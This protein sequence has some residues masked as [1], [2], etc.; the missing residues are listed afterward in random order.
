MLDR[1]EIVNFRCLRSV[2]VPLRPLTI[3]VGPNDSGKSALLTAIA[4]AAGRYT[5]QLPDDRWR[6]DPPN[7]IRVSASSRTGAVTFTAG[8]DGGYGRNVMGNNPCARTVVFRLPSHGVP[9]LGAGFPDAG[10]APELTAEGGNVSSLLDY[11]LRRDRK[12]FFALVEATKARVPG[13]EDLDVGTPDAASRRLDLV[14]D[15]GLRI[16]SDNASTGVRLLLF[17]VALTYHPDPPN[18]ILL[19]EPEN[20]VHPRR[21]ADVM[22]LLRDITQGKHCGHAAQ[23]I[24]TTHS[25]YLLDHVDLKTDQVLVFKRNDDGSRTAEPADAER[26]KTFLDEFMLGEVWF[27]E[28]EEGLVGRKA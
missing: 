7:S 22:A 15:G 17:F 1:I 2:K 12:R 4:L 20:G 18:I 16:P 5:A 14:I 13:L 19:E 21:L 25:P 6:R 8:S 26:L 28:G 3:L 23:V 24:L 10:I 27:N 9:M 11:L